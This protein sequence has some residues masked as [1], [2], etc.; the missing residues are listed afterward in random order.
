[1]SRLDEIINGD[2][3][4]RDDE[5]ERI[6]RERDVDRAELLN[7]PIDWLAEYRRQWCECCGGST[8]QAELPSGMYCCSMCGSENGFGPRSLL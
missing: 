6:A 5:A 4:P 1:M 3:P 2:E 8:L 7:R